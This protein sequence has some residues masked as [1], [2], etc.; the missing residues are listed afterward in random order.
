MT[1]DLTFSEAFSALEKLVEEIENDNIPLDTL[2]EKVKEANEYIKFCEIK[3]RKIEADINDVT[4][5]D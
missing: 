4:K 2:A 1:K 3:L 5:T